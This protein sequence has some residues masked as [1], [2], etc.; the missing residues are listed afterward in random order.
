MRRDLITESRLLRNVVDALRLALDERPAG[1]RENALWRGVEACG[2]ASGIFDEAIEI[3][4][5]AG[6]ASRRHGRL[7]SGPTPK[8]KPQRLAS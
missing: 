4:L 1:C 2:V 5:D 6:W 3:M 8:A 7:F